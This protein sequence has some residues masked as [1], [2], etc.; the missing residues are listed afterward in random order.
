MF[1]SIFIFVSS[2]SPD[3]LMQ[4]GVLS[5]V[6]AIASYFSFRKNSS[7]LYIYLPIGLGLVAILMRASSGVPS[8]EAL[9]IPMALWWSSALLVLWNGIRPN[10]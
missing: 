4:I 6:I 9:I 8:G 2:A 5:F 7:A 1:F 10:K 3:A